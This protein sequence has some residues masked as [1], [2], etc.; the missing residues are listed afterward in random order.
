MNAKPDFASMAL[1]AVDSYNL[2]GLDPS[3]SSEEIRHA[4][5]KVPWLATGPV[6]FDDVKKIHSDILTPL[7]LWNK[8]K[9]S[10]Y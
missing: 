10:L 4:Y 5:K 8:L 3:A 7:K 6:M 2:L 9:T 1:D